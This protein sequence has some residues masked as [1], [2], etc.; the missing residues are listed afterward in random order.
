[1]YEKLGFKKLR[2]NV[3]AWEDQ[4]GELQCAVDYELEE[5][6]FINYSE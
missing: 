1:M 3:D 2:I 6:D 4:L 5:H